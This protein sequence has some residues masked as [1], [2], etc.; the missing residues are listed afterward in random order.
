MIYFDTN[1]RP[2]FIDDKG[3]YLKSRFERKLTKIADIVKI[4]ELELKTGQTIT[5]YT[6]K[7][8]LKKYLQSGLT[9]NGIK[10][11]CIYSR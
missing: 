11:D 3:R 2:D 6:V 8:I 9:K 5:T 10:F 4:S 7:R 1:I